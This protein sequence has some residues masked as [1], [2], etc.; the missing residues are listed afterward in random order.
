MQVRSK[1]CETRR[2]YE[3][4]VECGMLVM[5]VGTTVGATKECTNIRVTLKWWID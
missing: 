2:E 3:P 1:V 5:T 4:A